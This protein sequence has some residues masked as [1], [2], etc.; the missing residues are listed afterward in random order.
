MT[1]R[2][3][4]PHL[5]SKFTVALPCLHFLVVIIM[6]PF[7][8]RAPYKAVEAASFNTVIDSIS[9]VLIEDKSPS[10]GTPS[11]TYNGSVPALIEPTPRIRTLADSPGWPLS[12]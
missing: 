6:I 3:L 2:E 8:P 4:A 7:A 11:T 12:L 10:N 5:A 1:A 9:F